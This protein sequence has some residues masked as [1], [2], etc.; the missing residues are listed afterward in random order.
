MRHRVFT[1][2]TRENELLL[3]NHVAHPRLLPQIPG[4]T[5]EPDET[6]EEAAF[7]EAR[8]ETGLDQLR[9]VKLLDSGV[10]DLRA[11]GRDET[12]MAWFYHLQTDQLTRESWRHTEAYP[13]EGHGP[14]EFELYW[15]P[16]KTLPEL[17]GIDGEALDALSVS[18]LQI[19]PLAGSPFSY[20]ATKSGL[21]Q[22]AYL[23]RTVTSLSGKAAQRFLALVT[24]ADEHSCQL[25]MAKA[26][27]NFKRGNEK[28][29]KRRGRK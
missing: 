24:N 15:S 23:G 1:Y 29:A 6:P 19:D 12:I 7:R 18:M 9:L 14:V 11:I 16:L 8:E 2:I 27:G 5:V 26:T 13:S 20:R 21:V 28:Q 22:I 10:R 25:A 3:L 17:G 4:G